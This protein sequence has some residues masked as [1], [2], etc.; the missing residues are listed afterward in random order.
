MCQVLLWHCGCIISFIFPTTPQRGSSY[1]SDIT[2]ADISTERVAYGGALNPGSVS[3]PPHS[4]YQAAC[5]F[6]SFL[7]RELMEAHTRSVS[8]LEAYR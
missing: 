3:L 4:D 8:V 7:T 1:C 5:S 6:A 2:S